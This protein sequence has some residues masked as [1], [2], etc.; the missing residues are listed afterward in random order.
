MWSTHILSSLPYFGRTYHERHRLIEFAM[1]S[2]ARYLRPASTSPSGACM[3]RCLA[4]PSSST[5]RRA[6]PPIHAIKLYTNPGKILPRRQSCPSKAHAISKRFLLT[7]GSRGKIAEWVLAEMQVPYDTVLLDMRKG[8][9]KSPEY[10][11]INPWGK[12]PA[13]EDGE[14]G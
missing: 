9:H 4:P 2:Q 5:G 10:L 7:E 6:P 1:I 14:G 8:E 11:K 12:V 3:R 13:M